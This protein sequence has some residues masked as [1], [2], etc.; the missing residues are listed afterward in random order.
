[1]YACG[2]AAGI[3]HAMFVGFGVCLGQIMLFDPKKGSGNFIPEDDDMDMCIDTDMITPA[4]EAEYYRQLV[5]QGLFDGGRHKYS[6]KDDEDGF[7]SGIV[8]E[9]HGGTVQTGRKVR[10]TWISLKHKLG[11]VKSCNWFMFKWN[12]YY[13]HSKGGRWVS[14]AKFDK[15]IFPYVPSDDAIMKGMP[16]DYL[17]KY[18]KTVFNGVEVQFPARVGHCVDFWY[19]GWWLPKTGGSSKKQIICVVRNWKDKNTWKVVKA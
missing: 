3:D 7:D 13:W 2:K 17:G 19:P 5:N 18:V 1:M 6:F 9:R 14:Q 15:H 8:H 11:G 10:F 4:Q 12:G 16:A